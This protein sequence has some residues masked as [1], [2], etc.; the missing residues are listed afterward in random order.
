VVIES[1]AKLVIT[2]TYQR[3]LKPLKTCAIVKNDDDITSFPF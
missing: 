3:F 1:G 2:P